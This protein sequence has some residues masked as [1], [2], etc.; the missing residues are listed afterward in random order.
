MVTRSRGSAALCRGAAPIRRGRIAVAV[1][2]G[3][4]LCLANTGLVVSLTS[5]MAAAAPPPTLATDLLDYSPDQTVHVS[6]TDFD[7]NTT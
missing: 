6:G 5:S 3:A 1:V 4:L 7:A 2:S